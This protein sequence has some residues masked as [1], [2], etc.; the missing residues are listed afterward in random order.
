MRESCSSRKL[1]TGTFMASTWT[2]ETHYMSHG[3]TEIMSKRW[4]MQ[5]LSTLDPM[6]RRTFVL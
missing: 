3:A 6:D 1:I 4:R 2:K 5:Y